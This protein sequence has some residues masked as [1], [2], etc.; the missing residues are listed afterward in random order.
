MSEKHE[1]ALA[2]H[3]AGPQHRRNGAPRWAYAIYA[4]DGT[5]LDVIS[6]D[7]VIGWPNWVKKLSRLDNVNVSVAEFDRWV[8]CGA[9]HAAALGRRPS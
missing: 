9:L 3:I 8:S 6:H 7:P 4:A 5:L 1:P 2:Q